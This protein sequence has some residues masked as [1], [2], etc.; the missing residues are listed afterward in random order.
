M[1]TDQ[2]LPGWT[3]FF[4]FSI[5]VSVILSGVLL[6]G[7][8]QSIN[9]LSGIIKYFAI[10]YDLLYFCLLLGFGI[11]TIYSF[12]KCEL[13]AAEA[14]GVFG[15]ACVGWPGCLFLFLF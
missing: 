12:I 10:A 14:A 15:L 13:P 3:Q 8:F 6:F 2:K 11:Y 1:T 4:L 5:I 7:D 9:E